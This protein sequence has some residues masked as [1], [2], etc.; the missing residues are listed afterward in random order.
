MS[1]YPGIT[2]AVKPHEPKLFWVTYILYIILGLVAIILTGMV[3]MG[4][5]NRKGIIWTLYAIN[6]LAFVAVVVLL[7]MHH[8]VLAFVALLI[9]FFMNLAAL[10]MTNNAGNVV[11]S[12]PTGQFATTGRYTSA[13]VFTLFS[14]LVGLPAVYFERTST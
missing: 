8:R 11:A 3:L 14:F 5:S 4:G 6:L 13:I 9:Q 2:E 7:F 12:D 1:E 10:I